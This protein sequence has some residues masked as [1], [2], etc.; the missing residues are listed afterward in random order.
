MSYAIKS[1]QR[2]FL[3]QQVELG[4]EIWNKYSY[5]FYSQL[6]ELK[7]LYSA[8]DFDPETRLYAFRGERLVG[9]ITAK[10][11]GE[12]EGVK[13][14]DLDFPHVKD[15]H[16]ELIDILMNQLFDVLRSKGVTKVQS[17]A[18]PER[19]NTLELVR[20]FDYKY[21]RDQ[22]YILWLKVSQIDLSKYPKPIDV[23]PFDFDRDKNQFIELVTKYFNISSKEAKENLEF[24]R[25]VD[26][27]RVVAHVV[28]RE[29]DKIVAHGLARQRTETDVKLN[30]T[31]SGVI[32]ALGEKQDIYRQ[33][34]FRFFM[35]ACLR[36]EI[37]NFIF[38]FV[39]VPSTE[40][41]KYGFI[42]PP[43][44]PISFYEKEL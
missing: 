9:F 31:R 32:I 37:D 36:R 18:G 11:I 39:G 25:T 1:Y 21:N 8:P 30:I 10:I 27:E 43:F 7:K 42:S 38:G 22:A 41:E 26:E 6:K 5:G 44:L 33:K 2:A 35:E 15:G 12:I 16:E 23:I 19:R 3:E 24:I 13:V 17:R 14:A 28:V 34:I 4:K 29:N 40:T 20:K